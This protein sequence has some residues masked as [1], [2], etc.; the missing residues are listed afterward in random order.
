MRPALMAI[1]AILFPIGAFAGIAVVHAGYS[2]VAGPAMPFTIDFDSRGLGGWVWTGALQFCCDHSASVV[3]DPVASSNPVVPGNKVLS[4]LLR[5]E[6]PLVKGSKRAEFRTRA[7]SL[8]SSYQYGWRSFVPAD[9]QP[10]DTPVSF[11]QWHNVQDL[12]LAEQGV[13]PPLQLWIIRDRVQVVT[14][15]DAHRISSLYFGWTWAGEPQVLWSGPLEKGRWTNWSFQIR[16]SYGMDGI[17]K[18]WKDGIQ[19][20]DYHGP[21]AFNDMTGPYLKLGIYISDWADPA[22]PSQIRKRSIMFDDVA[23]AREDR[24]K[25]VRD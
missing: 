16:W 24:L 1:L 4:V 18:A 8:G 23:V 7:A 14:R 17:V 12:A 10:D 2:R 19:I 15:S 5:R 9:W 13:P 25:S 6:D 21:N 3:D 22:F 20:I 11:A